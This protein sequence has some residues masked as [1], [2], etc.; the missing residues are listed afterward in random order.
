M[1]KT[2]RTIAPSF[3]T[4]IGPK[5]TRLSAEPISCK[6]VGRQLSGEKRVVTL[7]SGRDEQTELGTQQPVCGSSHNID[8]DDDRDSK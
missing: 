7:E 6:V 5:R 4:T 8:L 3:N 1:G 2:T